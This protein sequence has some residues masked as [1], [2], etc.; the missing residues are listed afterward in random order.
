ME[1]YD[2]V[3]REDGSFLF[4]EN[5][6]S[7][8][9]FF[10]LISSSL[11]YIVSVNLQAYFPED[12]DDQYELRCFNDFDK[13]NCQINV[14]ITDNVYVEVYLKETEEISHICDNIISERFECMEIITEDNDYKAWD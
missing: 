8:K 11:Y 7:G 3:F 2:Q 4:D 9:D 6:Y 1:A 13:S 5:C 12:V 10:Q 14:R